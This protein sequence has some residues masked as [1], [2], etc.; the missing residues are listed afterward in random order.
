MMVFLID[1][2]GNKFGQSF[3]RCFILSALLT[4]FT[5]TLYA[6]DI[7][8]ELLEKFK[9]VE[10]N[11]ET[12]VEVSMESL[13]SLALER[14][15]TVDVLKVDRQI[16][17]EALAAAREMYNPVFTTSVGLSHLVSPSGTNLSGNVRGIAVTSTAPFIGFSTSPYISF[18]AVD[19]TALSASWSKKNTSG[20]NYQLSY[21]KI[22]RKTGYSSI[23]N[24]G[25]SF[26]SWIAVDDALYLDNL[27]AAVNIPIFQDWGDINRIPE[28]RSEIAL[29]QTKLESKKSKLALLNIIAYIYWDLVGVQQNIQSLNSS[30]KLAEQFLKDTQTRQEMGVLDI[31]EVRQSQSRLA[32]VRQ[33]QLQEIFKKNQIEDQI[34]AALNLSDL[35][36]GYKAT[37]KMVIRKNTPD[38][39]SLLEKVYQT[40]RDIQLLK[41]AEQLN[42]LQMKEAKNKADTNLDLNIQYQLNGY[43]KD[44]AKALGGMSETKLHDYQIG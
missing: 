8:P 6:L 35:P 22:S 33:S 44:Y 28:F 10:E 12:I 9:L 16:A 21:Q 30:I 39:N 24:E 23:S 18:S 7:N 19:T 2:H 42:D 38:F 11:G 5:W 40:N 31:I 4:V 13:L 37:E 15:T 34:R 36:Y 32:A 43:G 41:T 17:E 27:S 3:L 29:L 14:S 25:D 20:I 1:F 26:E